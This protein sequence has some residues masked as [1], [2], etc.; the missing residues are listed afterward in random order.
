MQNNDLV[1]NAEQ[2][3]VEQLFKIETLSETKYTQKEKE[4]RKIAI[5]LFIR[6]FDVNRRDEV[7]F[8]PLW[9]N[10]VIL[11]EYLNKAEKIYN[12]AGNYEATHNIIKF[13]SVIDKELAK[14]VI[15][16]L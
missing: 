8:G 16:K 14:Q 2:E 15:E 9:N 10:P 7:L 3:V 5:A 6:F 4:I 12:I 1:L 11:P 13:L